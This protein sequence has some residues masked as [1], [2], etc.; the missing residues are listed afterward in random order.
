M[1]NYHENPLHEEAFKIAKA[2]GCNSLREYAATHVLW[3][4][5][6][7]DQSHGGKY[8]VGPD[9][10][11][12]E[13]KTVLDALKA[14]KEIKPIQGY[15]GK[16]YVPD[17]ALEATI[18][19]YRRAQIATQKTLFIERAQAIAADVGYP[20][21]IDYAIAE[22]P[23]KTV[24][25]DIG[26][27][28]YNHAGGGKY[29]ARPDGL[30]TAQRTVLDA[31]KTQGI[32]KPI[33]GYYGNCYVPDSTLE[34]GIEQHA[35]D[36]LQKQRDAIVNQAFKVIYYSNYSSLLEYAAGEVDWKPAGSTMPGKFIAQHESLSEPQ[37]IVLNALCIKGEVNYL[38]SG[39]HA[40]NYIA[41]ATLEPTLQQ[42]EAGVNFA[43]RYQQR[44]P[45]GNQR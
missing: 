23:W 25:S 45:S 18:E 13:Q 1:P 29:V 35:R 24:Q 34:Q 8:V 32:V 44:P 28:K 3:E 14:T 39:Y 16:H 5:S 36:C 19:E 20:S 15:Y 21:L 2:K 10:L 43:R 38:S 6:I 42:M 7:R 9:K 22:I 31:L 33:G 41:G 4:N 17:Q 30:T 40:K 12:P 37:R 26:T 11:L 27:D